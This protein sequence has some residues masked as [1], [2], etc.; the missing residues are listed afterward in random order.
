MKTWIYYVLLPF[1]PLLISSC[2]PSNSL[3]ETAVTEFINRLNARDLGDDNVNTLVV[4]NEQD[5]SIA[6][7]P[8]DI[9]TNIL[10]FLDNINDITV[11]SQL[12]KACNYVTKEWIRR[13]LRSF[14]PHFEFDN[15]GLNKLLSFELSRYFNSQTKITD[16]DA[17]D[18]YE[19][20]CFD[21]I[22]R[23][24][25]SSKLGYVCQSYIHEYLYGS[26]SP[27]PTTRSQWKMMIFL[28]LNDSSR[29]YCRSLERIIQVNREI[30]DEEFDDSTDKMKLNL[31]LDLFID[32]ITTPSTEKLT[33]FETQKQLLGLEPR[34]LQVSFAKEL[35][36]VIKVLFH[37]HLISQYETLAVLKTIISAGLYSYSL[38]DRAFPCGG[39]TYELFQ[40]PDCNA[41]RI[42]LKHYHDKFRN[43][44]SDVR[45]MCTR[46]PMRPVT[47][48]NLFQTYLVCMVPVASPS[49]IFFDTII[50]A[51]KW[52]IKGLDKIN[53]KMFSLIYQAYH[54]GH[55]AIFDLIFTECCDQNINVF[56][57]DDRIFQVKNIFNSDIFQEA[58]MRIYLKYLQKKADPM[59]LLFIWP[60]RLFHFTDMITDK[61]NTNKRYVI[62]VNKSDLIHVSPHL[63]KLAAKSG[64]VL[65]FTEIILELKVPG[66]LELFTSNPNP[67]S[68]YSDSPVNS[69]LKFIRFASLN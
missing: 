43:G 11:F 44:N 58:K 67:G 69:I 8:N 3:I 52:G 66:L 27:I 37:E 35:E 6:I 48:Y 4:E 51:I 57:D 23:N 14:S 20:A 64:Q 12:S 59:P 21:R 5:V 22:S 40:R 47:S 1:W 49:L 2:A 42:L 17:C 16:E 50:K 31:Y 34:H 26:D 61:F 68:D 62:D 10:G 18:Q 32:L 15:D 55:D 19:L 54:T 24:E 53:P 41:N 7:L 29:T 30:I 46:N 38:F 13:R 9:L 65:S 60:E 56:Y 63:C 45:H 39:I 36:L 25:K 33:E 28:K